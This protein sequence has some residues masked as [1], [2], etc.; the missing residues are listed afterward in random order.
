MGL[1]NFRPRFA[2][3]V[4][5][6]NKTHT[7]RAVRKIPDRPGSIMH[8]YTGLRRKDARLLMRAPC[9]CVE[10]IHIDEH[11]RIAIEDEQLSMDE[12][13]L[14]A[15]RDGF[16]SF[17]DMMSFWKGRLPFDGHVYHWDPNRRLP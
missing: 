6:G 3:L 13:E 10:R 2:D 16:Q 9:T 5:A 15:T 14:L 4:S 17:A 11:C 12:C 7:I 8:L 1:Y